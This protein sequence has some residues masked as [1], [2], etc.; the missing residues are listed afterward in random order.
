MRVFRRN[1]LLQITIG[2]RELK[3]MDHFK[4]TEYLCRREIKMGIAMAKE[5]FNRELSLLI[6]KLNNKFK[7]KFVKCYI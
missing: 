7:K 5:V 1:E 4:Y 3:E 2:K 6:R